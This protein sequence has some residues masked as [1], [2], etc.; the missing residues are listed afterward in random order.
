MASPASADAGQYP[1]DNAEF[2]SYMA[3]NGFPANTD[4]VRDAMLEL[5]A[6]TCH[7]FDVGGHGHGCD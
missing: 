4:E 2:F 1:G 6:A 5:V 3:T 7:L